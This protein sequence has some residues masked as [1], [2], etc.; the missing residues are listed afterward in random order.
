MKKKTQAPPEPTDFLTL[1]GPVV[2]GW[3][4]LAETVPQGKREAKTGDVI[5]EDFKLFTYG[6]WQNGGKDAELTHEMA[7]QMV[8]NHKLRGGSV[9]L[10]IGHP[11]NLN[12]ASAAAWIEGDLEAREDGLYA[13]R[14]RI[15][16]DTAKKIEKGEYKGFSPTFYKNYPD[17]EGKSIGAMLHSGGFTNFPRLWD[18]DSHPY[19]MSEVNPR[20]KT[21]EEVI[22]TM[23][24]KDLKTTLSEVVEAQLKPLADRLDKI[25]KPKSTEKPTELAVQL[26][27]RD[28]K[29]TTLADENK[30]LSK[31]V[32]RMELSGYE[33]DIRKLVADAKG[34][35][36]IAPADLTGFEESPIKWLSE[37]P[38]HGTDTEDGI[39][40]LAAHFATLE[41]NSKVDLRGRISGEDAEASSKE[42]PIDPKDSGVIQMAAELS[43]TPE[44]MAEANRLAAA[45]LAEEEM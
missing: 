44:Q 37:T 34:L 9:A 36:K 2:C 19:L 24:L 20:A 45:S 39:Q 18:L 31:K 43:I 42:F 17:P 27:E 1:S 21:P 35:G 30:T 13:K 4:P 40:C 10:T 23:T 38:T 12:G 33:R 22:P 3:I 28:T 32:T 14:V 5:L 8:A 41:P 11:E 26:A 6:P 7:D 25:E 29:I 16:A 15:L